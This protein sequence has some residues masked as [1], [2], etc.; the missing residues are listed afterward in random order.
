LYSPLK[1]DGIP[2]ERSGR[3]A[4]IDKVVCGESKRDLVQEKRMSANLY[5]GIDIAKLKFDVAVQVGSKWRSRVFDNTAVG[6]ADFIAWLTPLAGEAAL[7]VCMEAT[8][9]YYEAL[10]IYLVERSVKVSVINPFQIAQFAKA[11][12]E[13][14]KTDRQDA[15]TIAR[16]AATQSPSAWQAPPE[17]TRVL[18]DL[19]R[20]LD[21]LL[22]MER[23]EKNRQAVSNEVVQASI[24]SMLAVLAQQIK[25]VK[26]AI[27]EHID[28]HPDLRHG[29]EL[30]DSIPGVGAATITLVL[31]ELPTS[32]RQNVRRA[33]AF[34]GLAPR[35][36]ESGTSVKGRSRL[37]KQGASRLR[38]GLYFPAI[39]A[40]KHNPVVKA[41]YQRMLQNGLT[42]KQ[43]VCA[44]MRK[45]LHLI[46]GVL[47]SG[48]PF[49]P[50]L[51]N[52]KNA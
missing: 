52:I 50:S 43:A 3:S 8:G 7:Q 23:Q 4:C 44:A 37:S 45:L 36:I 38:K 18:R 2:S 30:L 46:I 47:K 39:V 12:G 31:A 28:H 13:R 10:A 26:A 24:E 33:D 25:T 32:V 9:I 35:R 20:R 16:F 5:V 22:A 14:N 11:T 41:F 48:K 15:K 21:G 6:F 40:C 34:T 29:A 19:L 1:T 49:D 27:A 51:H 42:K 17:H